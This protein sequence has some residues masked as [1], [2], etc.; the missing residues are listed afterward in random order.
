MAEAALAAG[1]TA[2]ARALVGAL[3]RQWAGADSGAVDVRRARLLWAALS[4]QP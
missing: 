2:A 4:G 3:V 1:D